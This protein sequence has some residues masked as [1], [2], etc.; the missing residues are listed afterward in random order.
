MPW[1]HLDGEVPAY[2]R[3][4]L[5]PCRGI[6]AKKRELE[7]QEVAVRAMIGDEK[8]VSKIGANAWEVVLG[9]VSYTHL[10]AHETGAYL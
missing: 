2:D 8:F 3:E 9:P 1:Q 6:A 5:A 7:G 4:H 10:R